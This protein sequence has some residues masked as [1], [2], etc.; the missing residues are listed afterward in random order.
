MIAF[1]VF[2]VVGSVVS[3]VGLAVPL[4]VGIPMLSVPCVLQ[5]R[6][7]VGIPIFSCC[8]KK[9]GCR[10]IPAVLL[11][12]GVP[13]QSRGDAGK[14]NLHGMGILQG[15]WTQWRENWSLVYGERGFGEHIQ[16]VSLS[17]CVHAV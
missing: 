2:P 3:V 8:L 11:Q 17:A 13:V 14:T 16:V 9:C 6:W 15:F 7:V 10:P 5:P 4:D 12:R 1:F